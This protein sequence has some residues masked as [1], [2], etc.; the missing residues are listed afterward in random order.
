MII[1]R[2][3]SVDSTN[4]YIEK[5][6]KGGENAVVCADEQTGGMGTKGRSFCSEKGGLYVSRLVFY[7]NLD[8]KDCYKINVNAAMAVVKTLLAYGIKPQIKWPNDILVGGKKICGILIKNALSGNKISYSI[9]GTGINVNN[10]LP[11]ELK[12]IATN[13]KTE[14]GKELDLN[15]VFLTFNLN[16]A[17]N[18]TIE[19]YKKY[20]AVIGREITVLRGETSYKAVCEDILPDG[21][22]KLEN[23]EL[24]SAAEINLKIKI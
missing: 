8:A 14:C 24:L 2:L 15:A 9:T 12:N 5:Y 16:S 1:E 20:S 19:E 3:Q 17:G 21:R 7:D 18:C 13:M 6:V 4:K 22:L 23:G 10:D 11:E